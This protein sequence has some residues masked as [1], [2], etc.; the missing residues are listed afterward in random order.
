ME[1]LQHAGRQGNIFGNPS[2]SAVIHTTYAISPTLLNEVAF[3]YNGNR[4]NITP[5]G[6]I[7]A[8]SSF[9]FN[10]LFTGPNNDN[11]IPDINLQGSTGAVFGNNSWPWDNKADD[12]Q[13][14]DDVSWTKGAHQFKFG[15]SW[16]LYKKVQDLFGNTQGAFNFGGSYTGL[17]L[18]I[19]SSASPADTTSSLCRITAYG[20]MFPGRLHPGQ[21]A[22]DETTDP[23]PG[24]ALGW[25]AAHLR[26]Q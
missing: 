10:R 18:P 15:G 6:L 4:I 13:I 21:L 20:T 22:R 16:A 3:N 17:T 24:S 9:T 14:R 1:H 5:T 8:P 7:A 11:R 19:S 26:S 25:R 12:Y 23:E 2:Y